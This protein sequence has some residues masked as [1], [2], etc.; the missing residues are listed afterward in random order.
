MNVKEHQVYHNLTS[1]NVLSVVF[2]FFLTGAFSE[3]ID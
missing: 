1:E 3:I 2:F